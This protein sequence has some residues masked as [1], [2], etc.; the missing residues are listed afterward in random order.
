MD[1]LS[2]IIAA[3]V[4]LVLLITFGTMTFTKGHTVLFIFGF[5]LPLLW[6]VGAFLPATHA[7]ST[8]AARAR[9]R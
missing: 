7:A 9:L 8:A 3:V 4:Y 5:L 6:I 1:L 2:W